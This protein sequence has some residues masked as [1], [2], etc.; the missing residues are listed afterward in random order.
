MLNNIKINNKFN[1]GKST[2][3]GLATGVWIRDI[4]NDVIYCMFTSCGTR[5]VTPLTNF[6]NTSG[7]VKRYYPGP[8]DKICTKGLTPLSKLR[9]YVIDSSVDCKKHIGYFIFLLKQQYPLMKF[10][11]STTFLMDKRRDNLLVITSK[12]NIDLYTYYKSCNSSVERLFIEKII[13]KD[14]HM[15]SYLLF[16]KNL[17]YTPNISSQIIE[18]MVPQLKIDRGT[19][20]TYFLELMK[21]YDPSIPTIHKI[22]VESPLTR[23]NVNFFAE[24]YIVN[25]YL[26]CFEKYSSKNK[27]DILKLTL[28][29]ATQKGSF[30]RELSLK[31]TGQPEGDFMMDYILKKTIKV[32]TIGD[33]KNSPFSKSDLE[34]I[35]LKPLYTSEV[36]DNNL[37]NYIDIYLTTLLDKSNNNIVVT[38]FLKLMNNVSDLK[39][40]L[41][42]LNEFLLEN[43]NESFARMNWLVLIDNKSFTEHGEHKE[44][45]NLIDQKDVESFNSETLSNKNTFKQWSKD[46]EITGSADKLKNKILSGYYDNIGKSNIKDMYNNDNS[47]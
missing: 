21:K 12:Q 32:N 35:F 14:I 41:H 42:L 2:G 23:A 20:F 45:I 26:L 4:S 38:D 24:L 34:Y 3:A 40:K 18:H 7:I 10:V 17:S 19:V 47:I 16:T 43:N 37:E 28:L 36:S 8:I 33:V 13:N 11:P 22:F 6:N 25:E 31:N 5:S 1:G 30:E 29:I 44:N 27:I 15:I 46:F 39:I 9:S